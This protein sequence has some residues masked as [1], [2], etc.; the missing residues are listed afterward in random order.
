MFLLLKRY[1]TIL[2]SSFCLI[3]I[4]FN[5]KLKQEL[6]KFQLKDEFLVKFKSEYELISS[7]SYNALENNSSN[8]FLG[9]K[10]S[11]NKYLLNESE[12]LRF[13]V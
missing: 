5:Y 2:I 1:F 7:T 9:N 12:G 10:N 8:S 13:F 6:I 4:Y 3:L 11:S